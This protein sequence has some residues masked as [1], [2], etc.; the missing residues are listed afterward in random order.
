MM[1][2]DFSNIKHILS[3]SRQIAEEIGNHFISPEHLVL[4]MLEGEQFNEAWGILLLLD[5][6]YKDCTSVLREALSEANESNLP[7]KPLRLSSSAQKVLNSVHQEVKNLGHKTANSLHLLLA[8]LR[9]EDSYSARTLAKY[10]VNYGGITH[11]FQ[12]LAEYVSIGNGFDLAGFLKLIAKIEELP[13]DHEIWNLI[14]WKNKEQLMKDIS[15]DLLDDTEDDEGDDELLIFGS[16][17]DENDDVAEDLI[18][19]NDLAAPFSG[20]SDS[21]ARR[22]P[23]C[24]LDTITTN[25]SDPAVNV[26]FDPLIRREHE[27]QRMAQILSRRRKNNPI[28]VG[29]PGVGKSAI[30]NGLATQISQG[31]VSLALYGKRILS[32]DLMAVIAGTKYRGEFEERMKQLIKELKSDPD[33]ILFIDEIH[34]II[35]AGNPSGALDAANILKPALADGSIQCIGT[36]TTEEYRKYIAKDAALERRF[37][38]IM[39]EPSTEEDTRQILSQLREKYERY[40]GVKYTQQAIDSAVHL[41]ARYIPDRFF[42]DKALDIIDEAGANAQ[43][44]SAQATKNIKNLVQKIGDTLKQKRVAIA[45]E[46]YDKAGK[47]KMEENQLQDA[48][49]I[50]HLEWK[51]NRHSAKEEVTEHHIAKVVSAISGVP[52]EKMTKTESNRLLSMR[53]VIKKQIIG[54]DEAVDIVVKS[55]IRNR[56]GLRNPNRPIGTFL[57]MGPTGVGKTQLAKTIA[58]SVFD[59]E[60]ALIRLDMSEY[61]EKFSSS[62]LLG[63][64]P[65]YVGY[66][67]GGQ[68]S[69]QV[70]QKPYSVILLDEIEKAHP[71][72]F[73]LLLQV[74][75]EGRL[76]D[77]SKRQVDFRNTIIIM[78]SNVGSKQAQQFGLSIGFANSS[79]NDAAEK[80]TRSIITKE[81]KNTFSPEFLNRIDNI[82]SFKHLNK[83]ALHKII[84]IELLGLQKRLLELGHHLKVN[85]SAKEFL[86][87]KGYLPEYGARPLKRTLQYYVE[88]EVAE[89]LMKKSTTEEQ[90]Y[91]IHISKNK[92]HQADRLSLSFKLKKDPTHSQQN[93]LG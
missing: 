82:V 56:T 65:G 46:D 8:V 90:G 26:H 74:L 7:E 35:G 93:R 49:K 69:E 38:R 54:Q 44:D 6:P 55:I 24:I 60:Q 84:D 22:G 39:V 88:D 28:L 13:Q 77:G 87:E 33:I 91:V 42:P 2:S 9:H 18:E 15:D 71:D 23:S 79:E 92:S 73:T 53:E 30:V 51:E 89:F 62:R 5:I 78:T 70:R 31:N 81:L 66:D 17:S 57:F 76:T 83:G 36:T 21:G 32:L 1:D 45:A 52:V 37:Q 41:A 85:A 68:L 10:N 3:R 43:H 19:E 72:I 61:M 29:E 58:D 25:L 80:H 50:K 67:E 48:I 16:N 86:L 12:L 27:L 11:L 20:G 4:G 59:S 64:P 40:H 75:D 47:L 63:A 34:T 14:S